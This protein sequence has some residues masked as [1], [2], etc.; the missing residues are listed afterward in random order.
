MPTLT[1][2]E[3]V[4]RLFRVNRAIE[5]LGRY[6]GAFVPLKCRCLMCGHKWCPRWSH[7]SQGGGC[8]KCA[9]E[10]S[11]DHLKTPLEEVVQRLDKIGVKLVGHYK[12]K[13]SKTTFKCSRC[14]HQWA[15][16]P[17]NLLK[18]SNPTGCPQC[19]RKRATK[20]RSLTLLEVAAKLTKH[21]IA[22][23]LLTI[24]K[25]TKKNLRCLL[26]CLQCNHK[27][28]TPL[29]SLVHNH[30]NG[31]L[32][33]NGC[34]R[35]S[36]KL[37]SQNK[38][39]LE[40]VKNRLKKR[41]DINVLRYTSFHRKVSLQCRQCHHKWSA[42]IT[43]LILPKSAEELRSPQKC[44]NCFPHQFGASEEEV[45]ST[46]QLL[47][48]LRWPQANPSE[49]PW[50]Y[51]LYLD[52]YCQGLKSNK[53]PNGVAFEYQGPQHYGLCQINGSVD[54]KKKLARRKRNDLRKRIQC[55]RH[56]VKLIV[57]PH[58]KKSANLK[59]YLKKKLTEFAS[60]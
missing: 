56:K 29:C 46:L 34:P 11:N 36:Q 2:A 19:R 23:K 20:R 14:R 39:T 10:K 9:R 47:T 7:L 21:K 55:W 41:T 15:A 32:K 18:K 1:H 8:P 48:G 40:V 53:W 43:Q 13:V 33:A 45:R 58:W 59:S 5:V 60:L 51:G 30:R 25:E 42:F 54:T 27:W 50:L 49:V 24:K 37:S 22:V 6:R 31:K 52:G 16:T 4:L 17:Q 44:P 57:I 38:L 35:C 3:I 26:R 12:N 28:W